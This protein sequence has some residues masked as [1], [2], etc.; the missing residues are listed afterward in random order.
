MVDAKEI[1]MLLVGVLS[2]AFGFWGK[3]EF[4]RL[5][6]ALKATEAKFDLIK[7]YKIH[8]ERNFQR[9][10]TMQKQLDNLDRLIDSLNNLAMTIVKLDGKTE[11]LSIQMKDIA[12]RLHDHVTDH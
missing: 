12:D 4:G 3:R 1:L 8:I 6:D 9:I 2:T 11:E 7:E 5:D 10:E